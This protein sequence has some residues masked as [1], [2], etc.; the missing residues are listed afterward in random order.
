MGDAEPGNLVGYPAPLRRGSISCRSVN[1]GYLGTTVLHDVSFRIDE[2]GIYVVLGRNGAGKTTLFRTLAGILSPT[3]GEVFIGGE[4]LDHQTS[5]DHVHFLSHMDGIPDGLPVREALEFYAAVEGASSA[6][7]DRVMD[8]LGIGKLGG[9][10]LSQLSAGQKKRVSI[11]RIF[12]QEREIYLLDE[13][14]A[15]LDPQLAREIRTLVLALSRE[16]IVLYSS[17]NLFEAREIGRFVL[18]IN[19]GRLV[20]FDRIE[21]LRGARYAVGIRVL[22]PTDALSDFSHEG[23]YFVKTLA[24]PEEVPPLIR[25]LEARGIKIRE[26]REMDNP[27]ED[28]F[29]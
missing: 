6:D 2:P 29:A 28:L 20:R 21:N 23:D 4:P 19:E 9:S 1:A 13:P 25:E 15:N 22:E 27:L 17:H 10:Y 14:T 26:V 12:F 8:L 11:A 18:V 7:V 3:Q 24:G 16:K 5:R